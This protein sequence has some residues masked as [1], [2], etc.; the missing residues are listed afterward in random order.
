MDDA[1]ITS[2]RAEKDFEICLAHSKRPE[3]PPATGFCLNCDKELT[4]YGAR[5]CD[6]DCRADWMKR[7]GGA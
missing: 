5:W 3:G 1:D 6:S 2:E 7:H 4:P